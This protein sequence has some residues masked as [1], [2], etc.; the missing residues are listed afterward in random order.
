MVLHVN[1]FLSD[2]LGV[3]RI[4][5]GKFIFV[6]E[7]D[8]GHIGLILASFSARMCSL[9]MFALILEESIWL[10]LTCIDTEEWNT[11]FH[12]LINGTQNYMCLA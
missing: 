5:A 9:A 8:S 6:I 2:H 7:K 4:A 10:L 12:V 1:A 3:Y 11:T